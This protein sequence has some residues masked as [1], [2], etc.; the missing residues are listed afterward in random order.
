MWNAC[1]VVRERQLLNNSSGGA[2]IEMVA[3]ATCSQQWARVFGLIVGGRHLL[4]VVVGGC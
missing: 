3:G 2:F 4:T 1:F